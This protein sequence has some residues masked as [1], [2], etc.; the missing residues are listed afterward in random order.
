MCGIAGFVLRERVA[1]HAAVRLMCD[2]IRHR[3]P[4]D[5][6]YYVDGSC[7]LGVRRLSVI[8]LDT[9]H[10]PVS[11]EDGTVSVVLNGEIYNYREL[12]QDLIARGHR[13]RT[14][15][16][17]EVLVHLYED[18]GEAGVS[19]LC[20]MFAFAIWDARRREL[21]LARDRFGKK[22]LY[23]ALL[24]GG[25]WFGS[26][27][28]CLRAARVP[29]DLDPEALRL[30]LQ[31]GYIPEP[32]TPYRQVRKLAPGSWLAF[33][34]GGN[35]REGVYWKLPPACEQRPAQ[36]EEQAAL[37]LREL[38]D[39][40]VRLR[41]MAD[42]PLGAFLSGGL[43]SASVVASM[44]LQSN[45]PVK[46]FSIGFDELEF[47]EL[48]AARLVAE[49]YNTDHHELIVRPDA[50]DLVPRIVRS[51]DE[52]FGDSSAIPTYVVS[53]FAARYVKVALT[54]DGG[55]ELFCGYDS[56]FDA[57]RAQRFDHIPLALRR[58]L[59]VVADSLPHSTYGKN[60]LRMVS[61]ADPMDRYFDLAYSQHA[62]C[63]ALL[64]EEW[65]L[66]GAHA[67][68][69][70]SNGGGRAGILS[71]VIQFQATTQLAG[72]MLVKVDR[73]SMAHSIEVRCP[74]LDHRLAE[75]AMQIP[76]AWNMK[77]GR[78]KQLLRAALADRLPSELLR[79]PKKGFGVPLANWFR[80]SLRSFLRDHL[81]SRSFLTRGI[82]S[83]PFLRR[84]LDE[85]DRKRRD[86]NHV[87]W[88][89]LMLEL[90]LREFETPSAGVPASNHRRAAHV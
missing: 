34:L 84:L 31:F 85:H 3:G 21:L 69:C 77:N 14:N 15:S 37:G 18:A 72:D 55:D 67:G 11:N 12:R 47:N 35:H 39:E 78:G 61:R 20:G 43:D 82:V 88:M 50:V 5:E 90:W 26:E 56:L 36:S 79:L 38:F 83:E 65:K 51:F 8:D 32:A 10:Q 74:L 62:A 48:P 57:D 23:Y 49:K 9:G 7:A 28:K 80:G 24:P 66:P 46:T 17:T 76:F 75:F 64:Q 73:M 70:N 81:T 58:A 40:S 30:Y 2:Q 71:R 4:D 19:R 22:P 41:M 60:Y 53:E 33:P 52:P 42:V 54:G 59:S 29:L 45:A 25:L 68:F 27:L 6:G 1:E 44:A 89:L 63:E 13:F 87:L 16:D 86:H